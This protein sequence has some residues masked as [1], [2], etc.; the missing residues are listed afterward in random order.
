LN[1]RNTP[2]Q[3]ENETSFYQNMIHH[4]YISMHKAEDSF[5]NYSSKETS[6]FSVEK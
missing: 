2:V 6:N 4:I 1:D 3:I 5:R